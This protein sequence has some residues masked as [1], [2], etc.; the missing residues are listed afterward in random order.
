MKKSPYDIID[1]YSKGFTAL[2]NNVIRSRYKHMR[3]NSPL[4]EQA[5]I[6]KHL[7]Q[8]SNNAFFDQKAL[9]VQEVKDLKQ[10]YKELSGNDP[11]IIKTTSKNKVLT[12]IQDLYDKGNIRQRLPAKEI[13]VGDRE[14]ITA[15]VGYPKTP[16]RKTIQPGFLTPERP[17]SAGSTIT[18]TPNT[19]E[20]FR[21]LSKDTPKIAPGIIKEGEEKLMSEKRQSK[22]QGIL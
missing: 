3:D 15:R 22:F 14:N 7:N 9:N 21:R 12:A 6:K 19:K 8:E 1:K 5:F 11:T 18:K 4:K 20:L 16:G 13:K 17:K 2:D 10:E